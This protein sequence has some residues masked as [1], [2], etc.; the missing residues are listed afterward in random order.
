[1]TDHPG[2]IAIDTETSGLAVFKGADGK[3]VP[4]DAEGQP[5]L[6]ELAMIYLDADMVEEKEMALYVRPD[7]WKMDPGATAVNG[8][9][10]EFLNE[11]GKPVTEVLSHYQNAIEEGRIVLAYGAQFDCKI[12]RGAL[13]RE[14]M[15]DMF[16][17]TLNSCLMR[18]CTPLKIPKANGKGGWPGLADACKFFEIEQEATHTG[19]GDA[20]AAAAIAR[21][22]KEMGMLQE[23]AVH[24]A[25]GH[26]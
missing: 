10:D 15:D 26:E 5:R 14:G 7:G 13:R 1:M 2:Y 8:L 16:D 23:P 20:R 4:A 24:L 11:H 18:A 12:L 25:K 22:L 17:K 6:A 9:T 3:P 19:L 21:K